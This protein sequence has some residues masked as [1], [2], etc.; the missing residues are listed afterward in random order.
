M[1]QVAS[2][3]SIGLRPWSLNPPPVFDGLDPRC[4]WDI[5][6]TPIQDE[7]FGVF[8]NISLSS[9]QRSG[10]MTLPSFIVIPMY[11]H[12]IY[13]EQAAVKRP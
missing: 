12:M 9:E 7:I 6:Q 4:G 10:N 8:D 3:Q 1:G 5:T 11:M 2:A 13:T